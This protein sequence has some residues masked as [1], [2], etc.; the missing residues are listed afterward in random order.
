MAF[1]TARDA[2]GAV[3]FLLFNLGVAWCFVW[4]AEKSPAARALQSCAGVVA[5]YA[6]L[7]GVLFG[8]LAAFLTS[9]VWV[10]HAKARAAVGQEADALRT[11][12]VVSEAAGDRGKALGRLIGA[13]GAVAASADWPTPGK[14][15]AAQGLAAAMLKECLSGEFAAVGGQIQRS[16]V[17]GLTTIRDAYRSRLAAADGDGRRSEWLGTYILGLFTLAAMVVVQLGRLRTMLLAVTLFS[18]A[19]T[20]VMWI[21]LIRL[22]PFVGPQS[23]TV[24]TIRAAA[25]PG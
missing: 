9:D 14:V 23:V 20:F 21:L 25:R 5:P 3:L 6:N 17:E 10:D 11:M 4:L 16:A 13:Y 15:A 7:I 19:F 2:V 22:D 1:L 18:A 24:D 8:L 12:W